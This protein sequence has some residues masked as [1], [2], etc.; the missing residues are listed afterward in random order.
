M[1]DLFGLTM[2]TELHF[3][4]EVQ[5]VPLVPGG[6]DVPV[7]EMNRDHYVELMVRWL[8]RGSVSWQ[9][10]AFTEGIM[11]LCDGPAFRLFNAQVRRGGGCEGVAWEGC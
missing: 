10:G 4:G 2:S 5:T 11:T 3:F 8:L 1:E 7:S 6:E 9:L